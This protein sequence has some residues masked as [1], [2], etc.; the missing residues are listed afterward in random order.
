MAIYRIPEEPE[1]PLWDSKGTNWKKINGG[2][3]CCERGYAGGIS[4]DW[5]NK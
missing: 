2:Q 4:C 3:F 5:N 1:G